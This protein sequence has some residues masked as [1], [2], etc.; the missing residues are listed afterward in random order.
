MRKRWLPWLRPG[1]EPEHE[2]E[3]IFLMP[4][5]FEVSGPAFVG[6]AVRN[7]EAAANFYEKVL[8]LRRDPEVF[9]NGVGFLSQP[10][11]FAVS[12]APAGVDL[13]SMPRPIRFPAVWLKASNSQVVHDALVE[14]GVTILRPPSDGRFG[15]QFTF[16]DL[17][18]YAI[19][20]YDRDAPPNGWE[21]QR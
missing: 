5:H 18:G 14:A 16:V 6:L 10:I 4:K 13:D 20:I 9:P 3:S 7:V 11:P 12:P 1:H 19:T 17:D 15:R 8:G 21:Q 2:K